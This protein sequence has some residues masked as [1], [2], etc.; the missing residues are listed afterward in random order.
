M[1]EKDSRNIAKI[2]I[3]LAV[4]LCGIGLI[5]P[6]SGFSMNMMGVN[7]GADYYPWGGHGYA[8]VGSMG[9]MFG[10][11]GS[12]SNM[13]MWS[14]FYSINVGSSGTESSTN[15]MGSD[16]SLVVILFTISFILC[17]VAIIIGIMSIKRVKKGNKIMPLIAGII[18]LIT[19]IFFIAAVSVMTSEDTTGSISG[20]LDYSYGLFLVIIAMILFFVSFAMLKFIKV[21]PAV[22]SP[23][24]T[25]AQVPPS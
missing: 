7:V 13:D 8:N 19:I 6:W 15:T 23:L 10:E 1:D 17:I 11:M 2:L 20:M 22:Q 12:A 25:D 3:I 24:S 14:I 5:L 18:S 21:S 9:S 4:V 16:N